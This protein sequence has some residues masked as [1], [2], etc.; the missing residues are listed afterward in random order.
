VRRIAV[1][2][3]CL[4]L[5]ACS[6]LK[7]PDRVTRELL[8]LSKEALFEKGQTLL[9]KKKFEEAR[10]YLNFIFESYPNDPL[11][12]RSLLLVADSYFDNRSSGG[13]VEARYRYRDY[14][15]RYPAAE[16]RDFAQY[17]YAL[18]YDREH[19]AMDR[20]GTNTREAIAQYNSLLRESSGSAYAAEARRRV[21]A[22]SDVLADHEFG[23]GLFYL[24]KGSPTAAL[25]RFQY[26]DQTFPEYSRRDR[27][28]FYAAEALRRLRR[29]EEA[30][31]YEKKLRDNFPKSRWSA[32][33][34]KKNVPVSVDKT[35]ENR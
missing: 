10:K 16:N 21:S 32:R 20:D 2:G 19:E 13:F 1:L 26:A 30:Q 11:G 14:L 12:Q 29:P 31:G 23:V 6:G 25:G 4:S 34:S 22:L 15:T 27:L 5:L 35:A 24:R 18:C 7:K 17:R 9:K 8:S 3:L 33:L 28:Y